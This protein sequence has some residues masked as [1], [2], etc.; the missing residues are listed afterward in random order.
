MK[1]LMITP[2][3]YPHIGGV[4]KHVKRLS[5]ELIRDGNDVSILT[6][7]HDKTLDDS[8]VLNGICLHRFP[9]MKL[10]KIWYWIYK[11]RRLIK[12]ADLVHC[13]D[14][15]SF[16]FWYFPFRFLYILKPVFIT[17]H[18]YE[19]II[20]IPKIIYFERKITEF[21]TKG[22]ICIGD[23]IP[24][25]YG[26]KTNIISYGGV[27]EPSSHNESVTHE[28]TNKNSAVFIGRLEN[29]TG[30]KA[31]IET[32]RI[33]KRDYCI[34]IYM[35]VCG[36]GSLRDTIEKMIEEYEINVNLYGFVQNPTDYL[37]KNNFAFVSGYLA[38]LEAMINKKLVFCIYEND[39]KKDYLKLIPNSE[40]MMI[41]GSSSEE[42]AE[43]IAHYC[44]NPEKI[45]EKIE[46][47]YDF[48]KSQ[49]WE[50]VANEYMK[51]WGNKIE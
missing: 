51:L 36:D 38:I 49:T 46:N 23:Y 9:K 32:I 44:N 3:F 7:K 35:D 15:S 45:K 28:I 16:I 47:A 31:Y 21:L 13:H 48:A 37:I 43:Q 33:L 39:L 8:E 18:G 4:E 42:L 6:M 2:L 29:D 19:G 12:N 1:I 5:E 22:N 14:F 30:I 25:W 17:F 20:P 24:K 10:L 11:H 41:T 40:N 27:D 50:K 26:T 34:K